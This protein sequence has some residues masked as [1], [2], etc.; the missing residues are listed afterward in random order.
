MSSISQVVYLLETEVV[1]YQLVD[2]RFDSTVSYT[3][4]LTGPCPIEVIF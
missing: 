3:A 1:K 2:A 4:G